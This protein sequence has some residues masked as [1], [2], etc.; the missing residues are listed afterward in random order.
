MSQFLN[1]LIKVLLA[2]LLLL[3]NVLLVISIINVSSVFDTVN[4]LGE[5]TENLRDY[6]RKDR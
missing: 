6:C 1:I 3:G 4:M 2:L 5:T